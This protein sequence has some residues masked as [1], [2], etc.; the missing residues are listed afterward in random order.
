VDEQVLLP[1]HCLKD[2]VAANVTTV[3]ELARIRGIG[4]F[5]VARDGAAIVQALRG[6]GPPP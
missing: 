1:G 6:Q 2:A 5:R 3:D 4:A